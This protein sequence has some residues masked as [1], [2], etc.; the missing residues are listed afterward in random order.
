M[1]R[2]PIEFTVGVA[3]I[4]TGAPTALGAEAGAGPVVSVT[5]RHL[6]AVAYADIFYLWFVV[7]IETV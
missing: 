6:L 7:H 4:G 3:V 5:A 1:D 2:T